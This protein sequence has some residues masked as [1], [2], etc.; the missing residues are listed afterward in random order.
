M[1]RQ[2]RR[3]RGIVQ[4]ALQE[5][6]VGVAVSLL[7]VAAFIAL[8]RLGAGGP[9]RV[10]CPGS[11]SRSPQT[12][13]GASRPPSSGK[14]GARLMMATHRLTMTSMR[15]TASRTGC[16]CRSHSR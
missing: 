2:R 16:T 7:L 10:A 6:V 9:R 15:R 11:S 3:R 13:A 12:I 8:G 1:T 5:L 14:P 4:L